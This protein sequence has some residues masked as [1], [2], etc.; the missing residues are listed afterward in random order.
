MPHITLTYSQL[1]A[2]ALAPIFTSMQLHH[3]ELPSKKC[4]SMIQG[5]SSRSFEVAIG[6]QAT[7]IQSLFTSKSNCITHYIQSIFVC[8]AYIDLP[9]WIKTGLKSVEEPGMQTNII[10]ISGNLREISFGYQQSIT[11]Y[12]WSKRICNYKLLKWK[13]DIRQKYLAIQYE[14][15]ELR[16][17]Q[18]CLE[19]YF[20][21]STGNGGN[22]TI[23]LPLKAP[24]RCYILPRRPGQFYERTLAFSMIDTLC[25]ADSLT[26]CL[27]FCDQ[28]T[29]IACVE[30]LVDVIKLDC[31]SG[32]INCF[33]MPMQTPYFDHVLSDFWSSYAYQMLQGLGYRIKR[34]ITLNIQRKIMKL[35]FLSK[36]QQYANHQ[37]YLKLITL[38]YRARYNKFFD[39]NK[40]F[41]NIEPISSSV[42]LSKWEYVP[43][44]YLTPY[45]VFPL[46]IKP[47]RGNRI[48]REK[49]FFGPSENFCRVLIRDVDLGLPQNDFMR[50]NERWI[51]TLIIGNDNIKVGDRQFHFLLCSNSQLRDR[52]FWFYSSY[53]NLQAEHIR[54]WMG[55]FSSET[56]VGTRIARMAL[57]LT[58]TT[59][60]IKVKNNHLY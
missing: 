39:I 55:D 9:V 38:Y 5:L 13:T 46:A 27:K 60:T 56:C 11:N 3:T 35:S 43:R 34:Q 1:D 26:A 24:P 25:L 20:I 42:V 30:F 23:I 21:M 19:K 48:L 15:Y 45:G 49:Q 29:L 36:D 16:L 53:Q 6:A 40:E 59:A 18:D 52:S 31:H 22:H 58:G 14:N 7:M 4:I 54:Q 2:T 32:H 37:C 41:D 44:I 12:I 10:D 33:E 28:N 47:M 57:S 17:N 50:I 8:Y 51:K